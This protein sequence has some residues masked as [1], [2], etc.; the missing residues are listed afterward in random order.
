MAAKFLNN[1][2]LGSGL[3]TNVQLQITPTSNQLVLGSTNTTT[4]S[5]T[6]PAA[7][8]VYTIPDAGGAANFIL[9]EGNQTIAGTKTFSGTAAFSGSIT[10]SGSGSADFSG[11]SG[12]FSTSTGRNTLNGIIVY[13]VNSQLTAN[14]T[15][16]TTSVGTKTF[17]PLNSSSDFTVTLPS[18]SGNDGI[19][20][21][22]VNIGTGAVT[23]QTSNSS[24]EYFDGNSTYTS[25]I[26][27][28]YD[29]LHI[30]CYNTIWFT[31]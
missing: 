9:S 2:K 26:L 20:Y 31:F 21:I 22:F 29:R 6:A 30:I 16:N 1:I 23:I 19:D 15:I 11:N 7:S 4:I 5:A 27:S 28:Q 3:S 12:A 24:T 17:I 13:A 18:T 10:A 25:I 14:A 8:R